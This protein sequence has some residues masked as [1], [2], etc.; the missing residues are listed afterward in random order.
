[1]A[2]WFFLYVCVFT[3]ACSLRPLR[4]PDRCQRVRHVRHSESQQRPQQRRHIRSVQ[5]KTQTMASVKKKR[6]NLNMFCG[7]F[8]SVLPQH[9]N[10]SVAQTTSSF[11]NV[12]MF[13]NNMWIKVFMCFRWKYGGPGAHWTTEQSSFAQ[14]WKCGV[15]SIYCCV[16]H[17]QD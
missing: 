10:G 12:L 17:L 2:G 14:R 13:G 15:L 1:M 11:L 6:M 9:R 4:N 8:A 16:L 5:P 3:C 7:L